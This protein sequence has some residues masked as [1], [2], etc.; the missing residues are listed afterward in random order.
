MAQVVEVPELQPWFLVHWPSPGHPD[1]LMEF[2]TQEDAE[3][4]LHATFAEIAASADDDVDVLPMTVC[5]ALMMFEKPEL[6]DALWRWDAQL[7]ELESKLRT[8][9]DVFPKR[10]S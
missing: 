6:R 7:A 3:D 9:Q 8:I 2:E 5:S 4:A 10:A 1:V